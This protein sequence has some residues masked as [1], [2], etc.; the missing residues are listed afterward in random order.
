MR[1]LHLPSPHD[2]LP[3]RR[4]ECLTDIQ[5][6]IVVLAEPQQNRDVVL[7][8]A[9]GDGFHLR[10]IDL[11]TILD[12]LGAELEIDGPAPDPAWIPWNPAFGKG[13]ELG[14]LGSGF[15][16]EFRGLGH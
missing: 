7:L 12:V 9:R 2:D 15:G 8:R 4:D 13:D 6:I 14:V 16:D 10:G 5:R 11:Q 1:W 3:S